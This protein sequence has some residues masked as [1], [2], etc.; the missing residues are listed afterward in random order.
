MLTPQNYLSWSQLNL[1]ETNPEM[2]KRKYL[3][4]EQQ[5]INSGQAYGKLLSKGLED[6]EFTGDPALD[7]VMEKIPVVES[8]EFKLETEYKTGK[9]IIPLLAFLDTAQNDLSAF[10]EYKTGQVL[11]QASAFGQITFYATLIKLKTGKLPKDIEWVG[12]QTKKRPD[13][14]I[15]A[16]GEVLVRKQAINEMDCIK[17]MVRIKKAWAGIQK[18]TAEEWL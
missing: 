13:G 4:G 18:L 10:K 8:R 5:R 11:N 9:E 14:K 15:E 16:T 6:E 2:Y 1:F 12:I 7:M 3:Y 17:M